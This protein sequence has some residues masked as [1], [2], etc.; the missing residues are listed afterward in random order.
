MFLVT[1]ATN[2]RSQVAVSYFPFQSIVA[3]SSNTERP[4]WLDY[5]IETNTFSANMNMELSPKINFRKSELVNYY[6]GPGVSFNI[7]NSFQNL[8]LINGY[9]V[10]VGARIKPI[11]KCSNLQLVFEVAPYINQAF[12][13]GILKTRLGLAW[14]FAK[15]KSSK[16]NP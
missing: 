13:G 1:F 5:K 4:L 12:D 11:K 3:I 7:A 14:N 15:N 10:D 2:V 16:P 8:S 6:V 9:F